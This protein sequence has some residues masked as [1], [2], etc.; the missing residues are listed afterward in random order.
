MVKMIDF[1]SKCMVEMVKMGNWL[2]S[3]LVS[4]LL[5]CKLSIVISNKKVVWRWG[6]FFRFGIIRILDREM[7]ICEK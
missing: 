2:N 4:E 6:V 3:I 1:N 5:F 7:N